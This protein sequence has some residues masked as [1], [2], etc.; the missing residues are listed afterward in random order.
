MTDPKT[1]VKAVSKTL[2]ILEEL[3]DRDGAG[4]SELSGDLDIA[5]STIYR[6]LSTLHSRGYVTKDG[7]IYRVGMQFLD[8]GT[9]ARDQVS[10][11]RLAKSKV[12]ELAEET[13]ERIWFVIEENGLAW[14]LYGSSGKHPVNP[15]LTEGSNAYLHRTA[16]GKAILAHLDQDR[17]EQ[18][19]DRIGLPAATEHTISNRED[20]LAELSDTRDRGIALNQEE[21]LLGLHALSAPIIH[22]ET[23]E[24]L[25]SLS[26]SG[27]ANRITESRIH[28]GLAEL[29]RGAANE[30]EINVSYE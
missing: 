22:K 14:F 25:G 28:D 30:I 17:I 8:F 26:L 7:D 23:R 9:Y 2:R 4:I 5:K 18:I 29:I 3:K 10:S 24:P 11:F 19:I 1:D 15:P 6:H 16:G 27:P 20:L 21:S 13:G 12:D